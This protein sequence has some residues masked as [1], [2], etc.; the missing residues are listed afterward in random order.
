MVKKRTI[1]QVGSSNWDDGSIEI[2]KNLNWVFI[3]TRNLKELPLRKQITN[4][5]KIEQIIRENSFN[6]PL[7]ELDFTENIRYNFVILTD[8][9]LGI[10]LEI[11][12]K[13]SDYYTIV[14]DKKI[15]KEDR[16]VEE[17]LKR[18]FAHQI[19][20]YDRLT[21]IDKISRSLYQGQYGDKLSIDYININTDFL[22][23]VSQ[24]GNIYINFNGF[25]GDDFRQLLTWNYNKA[26]K[27]GESLEFWPEY[28]VEGDCELEF[29]ISKINYGEV[30][31]EELIFD[32]N[33]LSNP[34]IINEFEGSYLS[35]SI[36]AKGSGLI[37]IGQLHCRYSHQEFGFISIGGKQFSDLKRQEFMYYFNP[38]DY[39]PPLNV[40]FS[41]YRTAEGFEGY[42][43]LKEKNAPFLLFGDPRIY[44]GSFYL[45]TKE[46][47]EKIE[48]IIRESLDFLGFN[49]K[50][51]IITGVSMGSFGSLY[52]GAKLEP[53]AIIAGKPLVN[54]GDI[55]VNNKENLFGISHTLVDTLLNVTGGTSKEHIKSINQKFWDTFNN[56]DFSNTLVALS[57]MKNEELDPKAYYSLVN[58]LNNRKCRVISK[59]LIGRH[60]DD[61]G[62]IMKWFVHQL[63]A[64]LEYDFN[65]GKTN[66]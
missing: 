42:R 9:V 38:G 22:G 50:E 34:V 58:S 51:L 39:Q 1:L 48:N 29:R 64:L 57:Y 5:R 11:L 13:I 14:C 33:D 62:N 60:N 21:T 27:K 61:T 16:E 45:G 56:A 30:I 6:K 28:V 12:D 8:S 23:K 63:D 54:I 66:G 18:K 3:N 55:A 52:Y 25:F 15:L 2:P 32:M 36:Y 49:N 65:R 43:F 53:H 19:N 37:K 47:E 10:D 17:F 26:I 31:S 46:Y 20:I 40:Y 44:G 4:K 35:M 41:G 7:E 59:G 24:E